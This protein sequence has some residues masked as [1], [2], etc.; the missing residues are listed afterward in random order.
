MTLEHSTDQDKEIYRAALSLFYKIWRPGQPVRLLGVGVSGLREHIL[1][2]SLWDDGVEKERQLQTAID[3][4]RQRFGRQI[5]L[6]GGD[7]YDEN[8]KE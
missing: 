3:Q 8:A 1:Q 7:I 5:V 2:L 6:R 4:L